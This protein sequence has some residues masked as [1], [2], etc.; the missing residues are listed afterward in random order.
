MPIQNVYR[1]GRILKFSELRALERKHMMAMNQLMRIVT[2]S[3]TQPLIA[4]LEKLKL[5][6][7]RSP[8]KIIWEASAGHSDVFVPNPPP[9]QRIRIL[10]LLADAHK[11]NIGKF[12]DDFY[13][14]SVSYYQEGIQLATESSSINSNARLRLALEFLISKWRSPSPALTMEI[15]SLL[16]WILQQ[17]HIPDLKMVASQRLDQLLNPGKMIA[18]VVAAMNV[19]DGYDYGGGWASHWFQCLN[20]HPFFIGECGGAMEV[21]RCFECGEAIGG[22]RHVLLA[23][24]RPVT[25]VVAVALRHA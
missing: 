21:S 9:S 18:E 2:A 16:E 5:Q 13:N 4:M 15:K 17:E 11:S 3:G 8:M 10:E 14:K 6:I 7:M 12:E 20:G 1:Y 24:N 19:V 22:E 25:G 23:S